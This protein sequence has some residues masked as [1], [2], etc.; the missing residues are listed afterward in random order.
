MTT[1]K[2]TELVKKIE[3][4]KNLESLI[5]EAKAEAESIKDELKAEMNTLGVESLEVGSYVM[6]YT[7]VSSSRFDTKRFKAELGESLYKTYTK[8]VLSRRF[9]IA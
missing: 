4:L 8:E 3:E 5:E 1:T 9:S 7:S 6:R 2:T